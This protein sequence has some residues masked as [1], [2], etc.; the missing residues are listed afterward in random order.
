MPGAD[1]EERAQLRLQHFEVPEQEPDAPLR[2]G[3]VAGG[4]QGK[5]G[6][7]LVAAEI[8]QPEDQLPRVHPLRRALEEL[9]LL[10]LGREGAPDGEGEFRPVEPDPVG[11]VE[12]RCLRIRELVDV[13]QQGKRGAVEGHGG[14]V[15]EMLQL[16]FRRSQVRRQAI[17]FALDRAVG[18]DEDDAC[19]AVHDD[20]IA[21]LDLHRRPRDARHR[22][23]S[24]RTR[25]D[26]AVGELVPSFRH[27]RADVVELEA[28][29]HRGRELVRDDDR[30]VGNLRT[31][32][33]RL[34]GEGGE[35]AS[36][37]VIDV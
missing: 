7:D 3:R 20:P 21:G 16:L 25:Q 22:R 37:H 8:H 6:Q 32:A 34:F 29:R 19:H 10:L 36:S 4:R 23:R 35:H 14:E 31:R 13:R 26:R 1:A 11:V 33:A 15:D 2:Q 28:R 24:E 17:V 30:P 5:I 18:V 27:E 12:E 9:V